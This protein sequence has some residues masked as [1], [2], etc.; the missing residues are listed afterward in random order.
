MPKSRMR[1]W[2]TRIMVAG[3]IIAFAPVV[4]WLVFSIGC[5]NA[6]DESACGGAVYLW[7]L[8]AAI[9]LGILVSFVGLVIWLVVRLRQAK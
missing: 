8:I 5:A 4:L 1:V 2:A 9:P 6:F 7:L 3:P